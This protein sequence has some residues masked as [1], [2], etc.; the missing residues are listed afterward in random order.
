MSKDFAA[1]YVA[2]CVAGSSNVLSGYAFDTC[3]VRWDVDMCSLGSDTAC[4]WH[5]VALR[6]AVL[7]GSRR[8][9]QTPTAMRGI[10]FAAY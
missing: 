6:M 9:L 5:A 10:V 4:T 7:A 1:E 2:G 3:K 8:P